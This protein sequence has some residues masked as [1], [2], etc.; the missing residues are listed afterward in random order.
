MTTEKTEKKP[1]AVKTAKPA[2]INNVKPASTRLSHAQWHQVATY[3]AGCVDPGTDHLSCTPSQ[4][5]A[6]VRQDTELLTNPGQLR[7]MCKLLGL[8]IRLDKPAAA[9]VH[10][11]AAQ[12]D[13]LSGNLQVLADQVQQLADSITMLMD[14]SVKIKSVLNQHAQRLA[15]GGPL[16]PRGDS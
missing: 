6:L 3:V 12:V 16:D 1:Q 14:E 9:D 7:E 13:A 11:L 15:P 2:P 5:V 8:T 10:A 4:L